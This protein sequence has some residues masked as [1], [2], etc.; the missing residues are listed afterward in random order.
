MYHLDLVTDVNNDKISWLGLVNWTNNLYYDW[1]ESWG[2]VLSALLTDKELLLLSL[3]S[4]SLLISLL[5]ISFQYYT[6]L[7]LKDIT[8]LLD[9]DI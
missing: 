9:Q 2:F 1:T 7:N 3:H 8:W 6:L 5:I 4:I